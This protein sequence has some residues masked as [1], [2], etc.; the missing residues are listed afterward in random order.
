M[1][2]T[3]ASASEAKVAS[4]ASTSQG[5]AW[6]QRPQVG[7]PLAFGRMRFRA[8]QFVQARTD[9]GDASVLMGRQCCA[10]RACGVSQSTTCIRRPKA[11]V[12]WR[13]ARR[14]I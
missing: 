10:L 9:V 13:H 8:P 4:E 5:R 6:P 3:A 14:A 1:T 2:G 12:S 11:R 7:T